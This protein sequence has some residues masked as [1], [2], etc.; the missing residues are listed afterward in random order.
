MQIT[1]LCV[2]GML[3]ATVVK[4]GSP[5]IALLLTLG[6]ITIILLWLVDPLQELILFVQ[7]LTAYSG[8]SKEIFRPLFKTIGISIVVKVG[9]ELCREAGESALASAIET[10]GAVCSLVVALPLLKTALKILMELMQ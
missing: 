3:L 1:V 7:E 6:M 4:R 8:V 9:G 10:A 2:T 5:E